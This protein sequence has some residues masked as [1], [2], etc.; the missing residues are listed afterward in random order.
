LVWRRKRG[1]ISKSSK[2]VKIPIIEGVQKIT[3]PEIPKAYKL[4]VIA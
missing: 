3:C 4:K 2:M 1:K